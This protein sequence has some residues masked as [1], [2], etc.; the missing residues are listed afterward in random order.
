MWGSECRVFVNIILNCT[1]FLANAGF[2]L[3]PGL[4][5]SRF[6]SGGDA[7]LTPAEIRLLEVIRIY[8]LA[9]I[10]FFGVCSEI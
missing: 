4:A 8:I 9:F 10:L 2:S 1:Y 6:L 3:P 7:L 5:M